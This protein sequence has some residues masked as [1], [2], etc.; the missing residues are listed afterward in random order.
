V[1]HDRAFTAT[2]AV[3]REPSNLK[4]T[5]PQFASLTI[6]AWQQFA[7]IHIAFDRRLT[8]L[9]GANGSGKTTLLRVLAQHRG[10]PSLQVATPFK[11]KVTGA[12]EYLTR[13]FKGVDRSAETKVGSIS[14]TNGTTSALQI[15]PSG[16]V[17]YSITIPQMQSINCIFMPSHRQVFRYEPVQNIPTTRKTEQT[18]FDE[19]HNSTINRLHGGASQSASYFMKSTL[20]GWA[21][22]GYGI[23]GNNKIVMPSDASQRSSYEE[24][25][26]VL[27]KLL[28]PS[29]GFNEFEIRNM[30]I[31]FVCNGGEDEFLLETASGGVT[32]IIDLA[33]QLFMFSRANPGPYTAIID[34][35]ENHLHPSLQRAL[36]PALLNAF[37]SA[38]FIVSTHS[39]LIVGSVKDA[40]VY[41]LRYNSAKKVVSEKLDLQ[42]KARNATDIL[43]EV[44]G[45][46]T[47][48][49]IW[50]EEELEKMLREVT[51][52]GISDTSFSRLRERLKSAGMEHLLP[53]AMTR[54][55]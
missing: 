38:T 34:E 37:P 23:Q 43:D 48:L 25:Q 10:W 45:V 55:L 14:Y 36:L 54:I 3:L 4:D 24:F 46:S 40:N 12:I 6:Q 5:M 50:V 32:T 42:D 19:V 30:E 8:I 44:L 49:P 31:V 51:A 41:V 1:V 29:L 27:R 2:S 26:T 53:D 28:P 20:I 13:L 11:N 18:A 7:D 39:P 52:G 17:A 21:I 47:T 35:A 9:T 33:W 22:H 16:S 15:P